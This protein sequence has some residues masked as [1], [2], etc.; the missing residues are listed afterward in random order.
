MSLKKAITKI[1][2]I[3]LLKITEEGF[4]S[5]E[6]RL[7]FLNTESQLYKGIDALG[8]AITPP[9][10]AATVAQKKRKNQPTNRVT[11]KDERDF[12]DGFHLK[13]TKFPFDMDSDDGKTKKL[14]SKYGAD[15]MGLTKENKK[16]FSNEYLRG[17]LQENFRNQIRE[18][19]KLL[20]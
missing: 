19:F 8:K 3:D 15:I 18:A 1:K 12:Y 2:K 4:R 5:N 9:Y 16:Q 13:G 6:E 10:T 11:L 20:S 17:H 14:K 7:V